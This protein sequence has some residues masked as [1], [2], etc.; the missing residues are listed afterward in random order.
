M[1]LEALDLFSFYDIIFSLKE[2]YNSSPYVQYHRFNSFAP[3][4]KYNN[5]KWFV[6]GLDYFDSLYYDLINAESEVF[7]TGWWVSPEFYLK[8]PVGKTLNQETRL[9]R[10]LE[11]LA[12]KGIKV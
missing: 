8:R 12:I 4:R 9:D 2:A 11:M 5:C 10:V 3:I 7:I 1:Q 6:D